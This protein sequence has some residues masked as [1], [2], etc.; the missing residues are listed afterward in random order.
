[1]N[2]DAA[3]LVLAKAPIAG[4]AKTRLTA[5]WSPTQAAD[6]AAAALLDTLAAVTAASVTHRIVALTGDLDRAQR[7]DEIRRALAGFDVIEQHGETFGTRLAN[8]HCESAF[9]VGVPV[10][11]IGM[12][13]PQADARLL[14]A[15]AELLC[16]PSCTAVLGPAEDGGWWALGLRDPAAAGVLPTVA[17]STSTTCASTLAALHGIGVRVRRLTTLRDVDEPA[18]VGAV[19][20]LCPA[21]SEFAT[22]ANRLSAAAAVSGQSC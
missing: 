5:R 17:M 18:D 3:I 21:R 20:A 8:A 11:Q 14:T 9:R 16:A 19:A 12:D 7:S 1:M 2:V 22:T 4:L 6:L 10:L 13:T 15:S